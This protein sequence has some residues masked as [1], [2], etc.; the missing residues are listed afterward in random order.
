MKI[1]YVKYSKQ[2]FER[3][4]VLGNYE[5]EVENV[6]FPSPVFLHDEPLRLS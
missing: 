4:K 5:L 2:C 3:S 6:K 1:E